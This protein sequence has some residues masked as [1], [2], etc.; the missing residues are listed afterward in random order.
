[1]DIATL[2]TQST[3]NVVDNGALKLQSTIAVAVVVFPAVLTQE[4]PADVWHVVQ[5]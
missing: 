5:E 3:I 4:E 2:T 1:M